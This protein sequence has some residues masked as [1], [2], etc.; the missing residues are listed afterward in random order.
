MK[1]FFL[2]AIF[3]SVG[4]ALERKLLLEFKLQKLTKILKLL[5]FHSANTFSFH[6]VYYAV[7][8]SIFHKAL[9]NLVL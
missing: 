6:A 4:F 8:L 1:K 3:C 5:P 9:C 2:Y 7:C